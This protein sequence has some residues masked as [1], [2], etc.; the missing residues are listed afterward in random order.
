MPE[1]RKKPTETGGVCQPHEALTETKYKVDKGLRDYA[2]V[3]GLAGTTS[4]MRD[5]QRVRN[6]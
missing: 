5:R 3:V 4:W 6:E 1:T 2:L